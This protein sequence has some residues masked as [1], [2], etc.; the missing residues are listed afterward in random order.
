MNPHLTLSQRAELYNRAYFHLDS[1]NVPLVVHQKAG[2]PF[3]YGFWFMGGG[4][5]NVSDFYG[6]YQADYLKRISTLFPDCVGQRETIHLFSGSLPPSSDYSRVGVD[7]TGRYKSDLEV[8][9]HQL[10]SYLKF[11]PT[12]VYADP[13]YSE[14]DSE[15][16][17]NSMVNRPKIVEEIGL[18]LKPGGFLVWQDQALPVFSN[19][20]LSLVGAIGYIRSTGNRFRMVSI[21]RKVANANSAK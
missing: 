6:S 7:P 5:G 8:D 14:E 2:R 20:L 18:V 10:S 16:Y 15:H 11:N 17:K 9:A 4:S 21:F 19:K 1:P 3:L 13:P 12:L